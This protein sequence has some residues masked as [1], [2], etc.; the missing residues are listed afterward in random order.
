MILAFYTERGAYTFELAALAAAPM[1][2]RR[3]GRFHRSLA[4]V[5]SR[6]R[7]RLLRSQR[8]TFALVAPRPSSGL[9]NHSFAFLSTGGLLALA[10]YQSTRLHTDGLPKWSDMYPA[11]DEWFDNTRQSNIRA[12]LMHVVVVSFALGFTLP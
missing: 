5:S 2:Y 10:Q 11:Y 3:W 4:A 12:L 6:S 9:R 7:Q 1:P 8:A